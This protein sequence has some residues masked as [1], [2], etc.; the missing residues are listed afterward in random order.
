VARDP[1][2]DVLFEPVRVGPKLM[3]NRFYQTAHAI[4]A[5]SDKPGLQAHFREMR[6]E[7]GWAVVSTEYCAISPETDDA[8]RVS[9]RLWDVDDVHNLSLMCD[10]AHDHGALAA[11]E[12]WHGGLIA[13]AFES[14]IPPRG[15]SQLA[16]T[17]G[18]WR[19]CQEMDKSDIR[20]VQQQYVDACMLARDAGFDILCVYVAH[21]VSL[22]HQFLLPFY[23]RRSDEYG[24][25]FNNRARFAREVLELVR[26][27]VGD[28]CAISCRF[29]VD[30]LDPP[31]GL[32]DRGIRQVEDGIRFIEHVDHLVDLWDINVGHVDSWGE[33]AAP[34]R[35][36]PENHER[37]YVD[38]VKQH[39]TKPVLNVGRFTNPDTMVDVIRSGQCDI[40]G[41]ARPSIADPFLPKKIE[42]GRLDDIR[43]C[44]GCNICLSRTEMG[45]PPIVCTQ[46]ATAG[47]EYRRQWHPEQFSKA[48]NWENDVLVIGGGPAGMECAIVLAKRGM[49]RVHLVEAGSEIGGCMR[50]I[51]TLP[52]LGAWRRVVNW[53][54]I[55]LDKLRNVEVIPNTKL[56]ADAILEYGAEIVVCATGSYWSADGI[57]GIT[58]EPI[59]GAGS[60]LSYVATPDH[61][62]ADGKAVGDNVVVYDCEHYF[63]AASVAEKLALEG[64]TVT[65]VAPFDAVAPYTHFTLEF[66]HLNRNLR[67]LG[68]TIILEHQLTSVT[69]RS[70]TLSDIW[71]QEERQLD[72]DTVV[73]ATQRLSNDHLYR[74][75]KDAQDKL[76]AAGIKAL[77]RVGDCVTPTFIADAIFSGHRLG[78][79]IDSDNP[80]IPLPYL[81]ERRLL[82]ANEDDDLLLL[83]TGR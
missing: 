82:R 55:Q 30:T 81:R 2:Y 27:A 76:A 71:T 12:L 41:A 70:V 62:M 75:L 64:R 1:R 77:H 3:R 47:E 66:S 9:A 11:V 22:L 42:E 58:N 15:V 16:S 69:E 37:K 17:Y 34:S 39:T 8:P 33:D 46:N 50:W 60:T 80:N 53:R 6:A 78:R 26:E 10:M 74:E 57:Q 38:Q 59:A 23:N 32:G 28:D 18:F 5:G 56:D 24:G 48:A 72:A 54:Q 49:R 51:P 43:E 14:R 73:L 7:G 20:E 29:G 63:V 45:S 61:I 13:C 79:E 35:T 25:S 65:Y 44:I 36:H 4:G 19:P 68:V 21:S 52:G 83:T 67:R 40:I 31:I